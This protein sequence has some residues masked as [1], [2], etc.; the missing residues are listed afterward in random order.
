MKKLIIILT[1]VFLLDVQCYSQTGWQVLNSGVTVNLYGL[2]FPNVSTGYVCG[3]NGTILKT[4]NGGLNWNPLNT[5]VSYQ[6]NDICFTD[7]VTG[8]CAGNSGIIKTT[9]FGMNWFS[10]FNLQ[11]NKICYAEN[12]IFAGGQNGIYKSLDSGQTWTNILQSSEGTI[13]G[14]FF[15]NSNTG[16]G[17][18]GNGLQRKT[19]NGGL[20]WLGG[21]YWGPYTYYFGECHFFNSDTGFVGYSYNSGSPYYYVGYGIYKATYW[22]TGGSSWLQV[23]NS[24]TKGIGGL[25]FTGRDT[26]YAVGGGWTGSQYESLILKTINGGNNWVQQNF[27]I[28]QILQ[29]VFFLDSK[30]GY[31]VG[32]TGTILKTETGGVV[33]IENI[34]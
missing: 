20:N 19:T 16:Y 2:W 30:K 26:G 1:A 29:D 12:I 6:L 18:G 14:L 28:N 21:A 27:V 7:N 31:A 34:S 13:N 9:N 25:T 4:T 15:N 5:S 17:M 33:G 8:Y 22:N 24:S 10:V 23:Y 32:R 11:M 3:A